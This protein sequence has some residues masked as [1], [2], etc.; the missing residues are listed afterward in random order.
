M[1][2]DLETRLRRLYAAIGETQEA[3]VAKFPATVIAGD[4]GVLI[5]QDFSGGRTDEQLTN[6][7]QSLIA[8]IAGL[9]YHLYK[10]A[11]SYGYGTDK[12]KRALKASRS[13][14]IVHD[15]WNAEKH[16]YSPDRGGSRT[17]L[18]PQLFNVKRTMK[19]TTQAKE[20]SFVVFT[21]GQDGRPMVSGDGAAKAVISGDVVAKDGER[22][23]DAQEILEAAVRDCEQLVRDLGISMPPDKPAAGEPAG[24]G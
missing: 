13:F 17:G 19:L 22:L 15:L 5:Y 21:L 23:G 14:S 24:V 12:A 20:G 6:S 8:L 16:G 9:E 2:D 7:L 18:A 1:N 3:D 4:K 11:G 10:W